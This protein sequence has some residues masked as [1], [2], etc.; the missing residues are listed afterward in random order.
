[1][2]RLLHSGS[3]DLEATLYSG[4]AFRWRPL[5]DGAHE[6]WIQ[7]RPIR[8]RQRHGGLSWE[9]PSDLRPGA[10]LDYFRLDPSHEEFLST[11]PP[12]PFL[13]A[14]IRRFPGLRLLRQ[15]PWELLV[16]FLIS[17]NSNEA[18]IRRTIEALSRIAGQE[19]EWD[20]RLVHAF[21]SPAQIADLTE[22]ELR[23][24]GMG[25]RAPFLAAAARLVQAGRLDPWELARR[26]YPEAFGRL[27]EVPGIGVKVA[28]CILL[29][30]C[31]HREAFPT[32]VWVKRFLR[33]TYGRRGAALSHERVQNFARKR[34][35]PQAGYAQHYLFHF[36]R[37]VGTLASSPS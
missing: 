34:F 22:S 6:G 29:Y 19:I 35:G 2:K 10:L 4:Q 18:K 16:S 28:D 15:D 9:G 36:R 11:V 5:P 23:S 27:L 14:A 8:I 21:P 30:G 3:L 1:M 20:G 13:A 17:Q 32:D 31:D 33:E 12:D 37:A 7:N 26:P 24:T 25:Y